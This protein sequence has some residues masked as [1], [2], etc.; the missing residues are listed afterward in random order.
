MDRVEIGSSDASNLHTDSLRQMG[1]KACLS[2]PMHSQGNAQKGVRTERKCFWRASARG[3]TRPSN[4]WPDDV[5]FKVVLRASSGV[6]LIFTR[7]SAS[8]SR[9]ERCSSALLTPV[10]CTNRAKV[11]GG[12]RE[13][14][15]KLG[16]SVPEKQSEDYTQRIQAERAA[17]AERVKLADFKPTE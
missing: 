12:Y 11:E 9:A 14:M 7:W 17:W 6:S 5:R 8:S 4:F 10:V 2:T 15:K 16:Y 1:D 3:R 13:A